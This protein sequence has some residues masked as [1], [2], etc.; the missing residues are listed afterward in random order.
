MRFARWTMA[1]A[2]TL[3]A[4][5]SS[6]GELNYTVSWLG[7]RFPGREQQ[8]GPKLPPNKPK[9]ASIRRDL[10]RDGDYQSDEFSPNTERV[11]PGP[12]WV[13]KKGNL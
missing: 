6:A 2:L 12:F 3:W 9:G 5:T 8:V 7:I 4:V 11:Q 10:N 13:D 1:A